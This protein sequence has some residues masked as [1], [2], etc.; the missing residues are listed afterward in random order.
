[1]MN[2]L[3]YC[4]GYLLELYRLKRTGTGMSDIFRHMPLVYWAMCLNMPPPSWIWWA[5]GVVLPGIF[6]NPFFQ[7]EHDPNIWSHMWAGINRDQVYICPLGL[8]QLM[9]RI[10]STTIILYCRAIVVKSL[11]TKESLT[12]N[13]QNWRTGSEAVTFCKR[14]LKNLGRKNNMSIIKQRHPVLG[15][16]WPMATDKELARDHI[17]SKELVAIKM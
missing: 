8:I 10:S 17:Q 5:F 11:G 13:P 7:L 4:R 2:L 3:I 16:V 9:L 15:K 1:M 12:K 6:P 14:I